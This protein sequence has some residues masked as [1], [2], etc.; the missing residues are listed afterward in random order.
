M[1]HSRFFVTTA[2]AVLLGLGVGAGVGLNRP[3]AKAAR[4]DTSRISFYS[5]SVNTK[6]PDSSDA[7]YKFTYNGQDSEGYHHYVC[8]GLELTK[9]VA[10][11][12]RDWESGH[13]SDWMGYYNSTTITQG[14]AGN[15][16]GG[17]MYVR[18]TGTYNLDYRWKSEGDK[19]LYKFELAEYTTVY[20]AEDNTNWAASNQFYLH[21][22]KREN[23]QD[24][25]LTDWSTSCPISKVS[26]VKIGTNSYNFYEVKLPTNVAGFMFKAYDGD[27][28]YKTG[29]LTSTSDICYT[30]NNT[31]GY[32]EAGLIAG[33]IYSNLGSAT[34]K[35]ISYANSIC[36]IPQDVA[37]SIVSYYDGLTA[38]KQTVA[39]NTKFNT[40]SAP[41]TNNTSKA[42][43]KVS[44]MMPTLRNISE[45]KVGN[46]SA[47]VKYFESNNT[48][49]PTFVIATVA[50]VSLI[51]LG[52]YFLLKRRKAD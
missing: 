31:S 23:N 17:D 30:A 42:D 28:D 21:A 34:Y 48:S 41:G 14:L 49:N 4:A 50:T 38:A 43:V 22:W 27:T 12:I 29:N 45:G 32:G 47:V 51:A 20:F 10:F 15:N 26:G 25:G 39:G 35:N 13:N 24:V 18:L 6:D 9:G 8:N 7:K 1:K 11:K 37:T 5:D 16:N 40:Y 3:E 44:D 19:H 33:W 46:N 52:G 2:L 36:A